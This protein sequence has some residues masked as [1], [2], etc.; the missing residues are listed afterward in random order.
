[1]ASVSAKVATR[2]GTGLKKFQAILE[3]ARKRDINES[4]TSI[5]V[6]DILSEL[7]GYEKYSEITSEH[8]IRSTFCDIAIKLEGELAVLIEVKAIGLDLKDNHVR[9]AVDYAANQGC[10]WVVL[11]N[12]VHWHAYQVTFAKPIEAELVLDLNLLAL[13]HRKSEDVDLLA[14]LSREAWQKSRLDEYAVQKHALS[15]FTI[16]AVVLT[17]PCLTVIRRELRRMSKDVRVEIEE[18]EK[19]LT[20]EVIKREVI[21]GDKAE[22]A[23]KSVARAARRALRAAEKDEAP[24]SSSTSPET[25][26][27][28]N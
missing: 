20:Q 16:A 2:V 19:V 5:I 21:E 15:R 11:T 26:T 23:K 14:I 10:E 6:T 9:Q 18:I 17:E 24:P 12:G 8:A 25:K 7:F 13:N 1:M 3:E 27:A 4:D 28:E 22:A